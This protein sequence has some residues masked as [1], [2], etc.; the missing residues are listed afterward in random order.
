MG[1]GTGMS[2]SW[3][4][5]TAADLGR[6]IEA[7][8][9]N[10]V[11]LTEFFLNAI[12]QHPLGDRIYARTTGLRA[13]GE[14]MG[15]AA[16]AKTGLRRGPLDGVPVSWKDLFDT[17]DVATEAG[18]A[19]LRNRIPVRDAEVLRLATGQGLVCLG[20]TH[21][22]E[23]AFSGLGLNPVTATPPCINDPRAVAG[24]SSSGAAISVAQGLA[25]AAIGSDTGGSVRVPAAWNDLVGLKTTHG[26]LSLTGVVPLCER[27]DTVGPLA[28][29]VE[30]CALLMATLMGH[31]APDLTGASLSG[32]RLL[33]LDTVA[34]D[35]LRPRP[36]HGFDDA[37]TRLTRAGARIESLTHPGV[38][39]AISLSGTLY[40]A[41]AY[42]I[43]GPTIEAAPE[44]MYPRILER[45]RAGAGIK[46]VDY[47]AAWRRLEILRL[48]WAART[49]GFD[50]VILPSSPIL[51]PDA[52]RLTTDPAYYASENL[53]AL[54]NA[55]IAN[56]LG[57]CALTLP[58]AQPSCGITLMAGP[59][60]DVRLLRL[61][62]AAER[63]LA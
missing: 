51:P 4:H 43:W 15:A 31:R 17:A 10:P 12:D 28:R 37:V 34:M 13:R 16:R 8:R 57:L 22:S 48:H 26:R 53:L 36:A 24:G 39:E 18:S 62:M 47:I 19:L 38:A 25:P 33:R 6:E 7:G 27:L 56:L 45:F 35:D 52:D 2:K 23:L 30:D 49:A 21:M 42:A 59:G 58:T 5:R 9:I 14:A 61:G 55:R 20:K 54:R 46:A 1:K 60:E 50:A 41:E 63:A 40:P 29:S 3:A 11:E 44:K 32:A